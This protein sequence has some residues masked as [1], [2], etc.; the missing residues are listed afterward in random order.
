MVRF[1]VEAEPDGSLPVERVAGL[2]AV[3]CLVRGLAPEDFEVMVV[4]GELFSCEVAERTAQL[5]AAGRAIGTRVRISRREKEVLG[6]VLQNLA[7]KEIASLLNVSERTI[8]FH[9]SSLLAKFNVS[10][11]V[12]LCRE[13][14]LGRVLPTLPEGE[15]PAPNISGVS[16]RNRK[17]FLDWAAPSEVG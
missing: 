9:V 11:R 14:I 12:S 5:L 1:R 3:H 4:S 15:L 13:V 6:G 10:D 8:K 16:L 17:L 2:M 7:N